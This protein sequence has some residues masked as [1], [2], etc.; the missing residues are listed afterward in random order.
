MVF[1]DYIVNK[2][3]SV[4]H[5]AATD[6][7]QLEI[8]KESESNVKQVSLMEGDIV[9]VELMGKHVLGKIRWIGTSSERKMFAG[10]ELVGFYFYKN[11]F[12][13]KLCQSYMIETNSL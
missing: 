8:P 9:Q 1:A 5:K 7:K 12:R 2:F 13:G 11:R 10:L 6:I 4:E 3:R